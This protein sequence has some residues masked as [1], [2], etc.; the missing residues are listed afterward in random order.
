[1]IIT[2]AGARAIRQAPTENFTGSVRVEMLFEASEA[3]GLLAHLAIYCGWPSAVSALEVYEQVYTAR[4]VDTAALRAVGP[5]LPASAS[6]PARAKA[7]TE[8]LGAVA[9][10]FV[11]ITNDVVFDDLWRRSDL[12]VSPWGRRQQLK[13]AAREPVLLPLLPG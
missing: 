8:E 6:D 4:K 7:L 5:R 10:K 3:S 9:P 13:A 2:R 12:T 11:Q 1:M